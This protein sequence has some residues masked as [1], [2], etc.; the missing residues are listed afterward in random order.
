MILVARDFNQMNRIT[1]IPGKNKWK[2]MRENK[3]KYVL[4]KCF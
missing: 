2:V 1:D 4:I 3:I